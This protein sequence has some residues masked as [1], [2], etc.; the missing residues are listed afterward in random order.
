MNANI[1]CGTE[2]RYLSMTHTN[3]LLP[4]INQQ[5]VCMQIEKTTLDNSQSAVYLYVQLTKD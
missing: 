2:H 3:V 4:K 5:V 1:F